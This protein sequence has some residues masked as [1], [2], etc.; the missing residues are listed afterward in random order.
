MA[1][2]DG[3]DWLSKNPIIQNPYFG[4]KMMKCGVNR[5]TI[6]PTNNN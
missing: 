2:N 3:A 4:E 1:F 6:I 5:D